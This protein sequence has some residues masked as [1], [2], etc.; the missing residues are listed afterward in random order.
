MI[1]VLPEQRFRNHRRPIFG[2]DAAGVSGAL[3]YF[4]QEG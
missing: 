2:M 1:G 3:I 4:F